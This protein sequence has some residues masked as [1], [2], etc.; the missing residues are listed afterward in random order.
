MSTIAHFFS[1]NGT[2]DMIN[3]FDCVEEYNAVNDE[4]KLEEDTYLQTNHR[5]IKKWYAEQPELKEKYEIFCFHN[6]VDM[7]VFLPSGKI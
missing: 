3:R 2:Y 5:K 4:Q 7:V 6:G 1:S